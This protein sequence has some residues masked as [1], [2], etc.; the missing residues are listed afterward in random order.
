METNKELEAFIQ[1]AVSENARNNL[2]ERGIAWSIMRVDGVYTGRTT[3]VP[4]IETDLTEYGFSLLR[5][6]LALRE[7]QG[8]ADLISKG[9][10][11]AGR[12]FE[13]LITNSAEQDFDKGFYEV[14]AA[15]CYHLAGYSAIAFSILKN[16][17]NRNNNAAEI[18]I[19]YLIIR[20]LNGL[21]QFIE[22]L[23]TEE[24]ESDDSIASELKEAELSN[25]DAIST[26]ANASVCRALAYFD[27][28]L[29]TG[30]ENHIET[31]KFLL[32]KVVSL[33][34][35]AGFVTLWWVSRLCLNLIDDLWDHSLHKNLPTVLPVGGE[36]LYPQLRKEFILSLYARDVSEV[37]LW[38][39][40]MEATQRSSDITDDLVVALP[41][42]AGKTRIAEIAALVTLS[43]EKRIVIVTPL[44]ALS[45]QTERSFR[46]TFAPLGYTVSSL[47]GTSGMSPL[48]QDALKDKNVVIAT[49]EKL[50]FALRND[51][52][53]LNDVGL[54][55]LDEGH[56]IGPTEREIRYEILVQRLLRRTDSDERRIVCLSAILPDG[57]NL[58]DFT[59]WLRSDE[60]GN[61]VKFPWRPTRQRFGTLIW[62]GENA[63]LNFDHKNDIPFI[64]KFIQHVPAIKPHSTPRPTDLNQKTLFAAWKF[65]SQ[66]KRTLIFITQ[67]NW[68]EKFGKNALELVKK[69]Y[70]ESLLEDRD[71][72]ENAI[73]IGQEWLGK[74]HPAV[75]AL[76][77]GMAVHH[78]GLPNPFL[79]ELELLLSKGI[80]KV[81]VASPTLSQGLN[82]NAAV[83]LVPYLVRSGVQITGEE[84]ANV[85]GR[86]GRAFV[87]MEGFVI[88]IMESDIET[89]KKEWRKLI[90]S[91]R[92]RTL[93]SGLFQVINSIYEK[94]SETT[95][96]NKQSSFE[97]LANNAAAWFPEE[98]IATVETDD[99]N[100]AEF[101]VEKL[102]AT[103][104]GLIEALESDSNNLE[105]LLDEA[106]KGSLWAR[107]IDVM[108]K[109]IKEIHKKILLARA[110]LIWANTTAETRKGHFA[111]GVGFDTG[112]Q[113]DSIADELETMIDNADLAAIRG[114]VPVLTEALIKLCERLLAVRPFRPKETLPEKWKIILEE[115]ISGK[116]VDE[117][118]ADF[119][120]FI[121]EVF[122]YKMVWALEAVRMRRISHG[123]KP[124]FSSGGGAASLE[125][126]VPQYMMSMLIRAGLPSRVAA[127]RAVED[128]VGNFNDG[129]EMYGWLRSSNII[130]L[131]KETQWPTP[132]TE[133]IWRRFYNEFFSGNMRKW[134]FERKIIHVSENKL[135]DISDGHYRVEINGNIAYL[136]TPDFKKTLKLNLPFV[137]VYAG[138]LSAKIKKAKNDIIIERFGPGKFKYQSR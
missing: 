16:H 3:F 56:M 92:E 74:E 99:I 12:S 69:G 15:C 107:Q 119:M 63:T 30:M 23:L 37:E 109:G 9:F 78:G 138:L 4:T 65:A 81:T 118:G 124:T 54:I 103:V 70:L 68:V 31:A 112:V 98:P 96:L 36:E 102:D 101:L 131:N 22:A 51:P 8:N 29:Q 80:I 88:H 79:R 59:S 127:I 95:D 108:A 67:A 104:L 44:R 7:I 129:L 50:D 117:I 82:I 121:E 137:E 26:I 60:K 20:D 91:A 110:K 71:A 135:K 17:E 134:H 46:K 132:E 86:A 34:S 33:T 49:P 133:E 106:L 73:A 85:A 116:N 72:V 93:T 114:D 41:T 115:W 113:L 100:S 120:P 24:S 90:A 13:S 105:R 19:K 83:L 57:K 75:K 21:R 87:D 136:L 27:F 32:N 5:A 45:A 64:N 11:R 125:N 111:M 18:V 122:A 94:L 25:D 53:I 2:S 61:P 35:K 48:D 10:E 130:K 76:E 42:S 52:S 77:I 97:Y 123:W 126:G 47:Y 43:T 58:D 55:I 14:I 1:T 40:Q 28:G 39:S 89:R 84:F 38:P 66:G 6:A 62:R 128:G